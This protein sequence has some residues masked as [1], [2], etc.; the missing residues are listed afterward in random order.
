MEVYPI[1]NMQAAA[2]LQAVAGYPLVLLVSATEY[3]FCRPSE[4][5]SVDDHFQGFANTG[6]V[7]DIDT[8]DAVEIQTAAPG[9][10][11]DAVKRGIKIDAEQIPDL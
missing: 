4:N 1:V 5:R 11:K 3:D 2:L 7:R 10:G 6:K 9:S 8:G